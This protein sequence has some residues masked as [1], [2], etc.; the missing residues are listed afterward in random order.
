MIITPEVKKIYASI[1]K[2]L[3]YLIPEKWDKIYL[4]ASVVQQVMNLE[5]GELFFYYFPK[6]ILKKN[7]VNVYEVPSKFN[8]N[9]EEYIKLVEKLYHTIKA[10]REECKKQAERVWSNITIKVI[11][12]KFEIEFNYENLTYSKY[13]STERHIIWKYNNLNLPIES[14]SRAERKLISQYIDEYVIDL[15]ENDTYTEAIYKRPIKNVIEYNKEKG[16]EEKKEKYIQETEIERIS[17]E[18]KEK[19]Q[20]QATYTYIKKGKKGLKKT[21]QSEDNKQ[22]KEMTYKEQI[23]AQRNRVKSQILNHM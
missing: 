23:E 11:G 7:P 22:E 8:L 6:G 16:Y 13:S 20:Q 12:L 14:F 10:L 4:Y 9:E 21:Y 2:Q 19:I 3:F 18:R 15:N 1:Q 17:R 5:T